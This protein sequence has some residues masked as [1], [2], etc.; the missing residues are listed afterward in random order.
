MMKLKMLAALL[1]GSLIGMTLTTA[2]FAQD[3]ERRVGGREGRGMMPGMRGAGPERMLANLDTDDDGR[4]SADE[5]VGQRTRQLEQLFN[6]RDTDGDGLLSAAESERPDRQRGERAQRRPA[7]DREAVLACTQPGDEGV[8]GNG[9]GNRAGLVT[10]ADSNGDGML[11]LAE[12]TETTTSAAQS[13]FAALDDDGDGFIT[14][15][16]LTARAEGNRERRT[17]LR[18]CIRAARQ[19]GN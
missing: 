1:T 18:E 11:S 13:G 10:D 17:E 3:D 4:I 7:A 12:L 6:R 14:E 2:G 9:P 19:S 5:F 8:A 16:E 15:S